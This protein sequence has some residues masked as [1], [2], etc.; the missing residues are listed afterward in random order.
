MMQEVYPIVG[1]RYAFVLYGYNESNLIGSL[2]EQT[3]QPGFPALE[4]AARAFVAG[5][6]AHPTA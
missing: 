6:P 5:A 3:L 4:T 2:Y 1:M